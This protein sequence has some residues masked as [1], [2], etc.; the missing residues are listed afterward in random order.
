MKDAVMEDVKNYFRPEL[1]NRIDEIVVFHSLK[2]EDIEGIIHIELDKLRAKLSKQNISVSFSDS[3]ISELSEL[4]YD[5]VYGARPLR[6][7]IQTYVEDLISDKILAS[8]L[9]PDVEYK[10]DYDN[11]FSIS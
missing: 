11:E 8:E 3:A 7:A 9:L 6:R 1:I 10:V 5:S 2:K 4:G